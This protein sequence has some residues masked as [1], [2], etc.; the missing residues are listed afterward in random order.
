ML[1]KSGLETITGINQKQLWHYSSGRRK[2]T[3]RTARKVQER[4]HSFARNLSQVHFI[5]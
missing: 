3:V 5:D 1:S 4:I 2:P